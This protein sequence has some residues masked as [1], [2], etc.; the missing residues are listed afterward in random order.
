MNTLSSQ[1]YAVAA[2]AA[3]ASGLFDFIKL[4][5]DV[6]VPV[7]PNGDLELILQREQ[8]VG[9]I[10]CRVS[11]HVMGLSSSYWQTM[12]DSNKGFKESLRDE[13]ITLHDNNVEAVLMLLLVF[14]HRTHLVPMTIEFQQLVHVCVAID[15]YDSLKS[16]VKYIFKVWCKQWI[17]HAMLAG[18]EDWLCIAWVTG[19]EAIFRKL[20]EYMINDSTRNASDQCVTSYGVVVNP[21]LPPGIAGTYYFQAILID[22]GVADPLLLDRRHT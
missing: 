18:H 8:G 21:I 4:H 14:H 13:P 5:S 12:L 7:A 1:G 9:S 16:C 20:I 19:E 11:S 17:T 6:I 10:R 3:T 22:Y 15:K 2:T